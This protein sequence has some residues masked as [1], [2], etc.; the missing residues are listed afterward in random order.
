MADSKIGTQ[1]MSASDPSPEILTDTN[2]VKQVFEFPFG[3]ET[4]ILFGRGSQ[5]DINFPS[6]FISRNP[7]T[8]I[9][10]VGG[11]ITFNVKGDHRPRIASPEGREI[12]PTILLPEGS[13][14]LFTEEECL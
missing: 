11:G 1:E 4:K 5:Y 8:I 14:T 6:V 2:Q 9:C 7:V 10:N 13:T 12:D 3:K